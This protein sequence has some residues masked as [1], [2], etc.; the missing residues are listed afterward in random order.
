MG[1]L[2]GTK[3]VPLAATAGAAIILFSAGLP[4]FIIYAVMIA[5]P[6]MMSMRVTLHVKANANPNTPGAYFGLG[7]VIT[8]L[9]LSAAI[10]L[11]VTSAVFSSDTIG[12]K[13]LIAQVVDQMA[14]DPFN[15]SGI[16][17]TPL[18]D[19][20]KMLGPSIVASGWVL[21]AMINLLGAQRLV[22]RY[23]PVHPVPTLSMRDMKLPGFSP[24]LLCIA[25]AGSAVLEG[26]AG[27]IAFNAAL[28]LTLPFVALG[29]SVVHRFADGKSYGALL[30]VGFYI[31]AF[32]SFWAPVL[33]A[34]LGV[35]E[36]FLQIRSTAQQRGSE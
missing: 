33:I 13:V 8:A 29:F 26:E 20:L 6:V 9:S 7:E 28:I 2:Q 31:I 4:L 3:P 30:L 10:V 22:A 19:M 24:F 21:N 35:I 27:Y 34:I 32:L 36:H 14:T 12:L 1:F 17:F 15:R 11:V 18:F 16:D 5:L 25:L 23:S